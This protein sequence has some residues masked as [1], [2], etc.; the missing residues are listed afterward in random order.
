MDDSIVLIE[1]IEADKTH[2][3]GF[4]GNEN[5]PDKI[6]Y[7]C[8]IGAESGSKEEKEY[9]ESEKGGHDKFKLVDALE[10]GIVHKGR[11]KIL[12]L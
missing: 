12:E 6:E 7:L 2:V 3:E 4:D 9:I 11:F 10:I 8:E 5:G 1:A